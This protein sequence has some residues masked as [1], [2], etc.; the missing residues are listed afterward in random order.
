MRGLVW[1]EERDTE[2]LWNSSLL[3][4]RIYGGG[5]IT[6]TGEMTEVADLDCLN[7]WTTWMGLLQ[8]M[9][10]WS[11]RSD[12][13]W[14]RVTEFHKNPRWQGSELTWHL[15]IRGGWLGL[16]DVAT[17]S[18]LLAIYC[19]GLFRQIVEDWC[20]SRAQC[21]P[22]SGVLLQLFLSAEKVLFVSRAHCGWLPCF[23]RN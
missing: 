10:R 7:L 15:S 11:N 5:R 20:C 2:Q 3:T 21:Y 18:E 23:S 4:N 17:V 8:V 14:E 13:V 19:L 6:E 22:I 9:R 16:E 12:G 1:C